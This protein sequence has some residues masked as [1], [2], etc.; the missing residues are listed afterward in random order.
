MELRG[1]R[2]LITGASRG[3]GEALAG[4]FA[5]AGADVALVA[6]DA[7]AIGR[8]AHSLGGSAH[9]ADLSDPAQAGTLIS[10]VEAEAGPVDVLVNNAA[11]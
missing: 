3:I 8:L 6:R 7:D 1:A 4:A 11:I 9:T 2:V 5:G 10:R